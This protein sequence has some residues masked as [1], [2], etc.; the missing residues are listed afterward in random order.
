M[1]RRSLFHKLL[2]P[3]SLYKPIRQLGREI[4]K[5][6][7]KQQQQEQQEDA[8]AQVA[9]DN[10]VA[11]ARKQ[12]DD[13]AEI[14]KSQQAILNANLQAEQAS[15]KLVQD[16]SKQTEIKLGDEVDADQTPF[17]FYDGVGS[18]DEA[19]RLRRNRNWVRL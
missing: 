11:E 3:L 4:R 5:P 13:Q 18:D 12:A 2:D 17:R 16:A 10:Q 6:F 14:A 7:R 15:A 9:A 19:Q 1:G 8:E